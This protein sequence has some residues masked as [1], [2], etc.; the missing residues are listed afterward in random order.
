MTKIS[1]FDVVALTKDFPESGLLA[2]M[3]GAVIDIYTAPNLAYEVEFC[4]AE[5]RTIATV[6]LLPEEV[7]PLIDKSVKGST[8][9]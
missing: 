4:D 7:M 3:S 5:G 9:P 8:E 2:G 6:A 1:Q